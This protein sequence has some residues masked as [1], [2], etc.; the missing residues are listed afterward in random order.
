MHRP[1]A[2]SWWS[3]A[4]L[5]AALAT[6]C[7]AAC[8]GPAPRAAGP[9]VRVVSLHDV[10]TEIVVA[11]GAADRLVGVAEPVDV[12]AEVGAAI[13]GVP[14]VGDLE[15]ILAVRPSIVVGEAVV[16]AQDPEL[17]ARL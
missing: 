8:S 14:R 13:A 10:T 2:R 4:P 12:E 9:S 15:S 1:I 17:V 3:A 6:A 16:A 11:L 5:A 7:L